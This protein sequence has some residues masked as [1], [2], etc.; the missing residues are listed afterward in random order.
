MFTTLIVLKCLLSLFNKI[1]DGDLFLEEWNS[2]SNNIIS[3]PKKKKKKKKKKRGNLSDYNNYRGI[4]L[5][6]V[7]LKIISKIVTNR[8]AKYIL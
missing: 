1:W 7:V 4:S 3:I 8:I 6:N 2:T 5:I